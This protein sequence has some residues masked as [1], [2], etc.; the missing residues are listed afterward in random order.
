MI[1][2]Y[3]IVRGKAGKSVEFG[4]KWGI[5]CIDGF[6][7]GFLM[8]NGINTSDK[9]FCLQ[10]VKEHIA[11]FGEPP[12]TYGFDRGGYSQSNIKKLQKLKVKNIGVAP[13]G[14]AKWEVSKKMAESIRRER[15]QVEGVIG[16]LKSSKYKFNKPN[17]KSVRSMQTCAQRSFLG[18]NLSKA[19]RMLQLQAQQTGC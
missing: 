5:N 2:L 7:M 4:L 18:Y 12:E 19:I 1:E 13:A 15:A 11:C 8:N 16:T 6:V 9:K 10:A 14:K 17:A 3:S